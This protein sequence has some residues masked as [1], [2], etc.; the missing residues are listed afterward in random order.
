MRLIAL[1]L[2]S[3]LLAACDTA[4]A[5]TRLEITPFP[6][7]TP[8]SVVLGE[9]LPPASL[10]LN[11]DGLS[12]PSTPAVIS[13]GMTATPD[14]SACPPP[15]ST[16]RLEDTPPD[17]AVVLVEE[18]SRFLNQGGDPRV[19]IDTLQGR[20][21]VIPPDAIARADFDYTGE[22]VAD[23]LLPY[24]ARDGRAGL[25]VMACRISRFEI[26]LEADADGEAP[27]ILAYGDVN[28]DRRND[29]MFAFRDCSQTPLTPEVCP[30]RTRLVTYSPGRARFVDLLPSNVVSVNPPRVI[31]FDTDE[32]SELV[33][34]LESRGSAETGPLR[35]GS[36]IYD[37]NGS[38]YVLSI[39]ELDP[40]AFKIQVLQEGDKTLLRGDLPGALGI[41]QTALSDTNLR[42]WFNDEPDLLQ[43]YTLFRLLQ[44]QIALAD[45]GFIATES[46]INST[47]PD[48]AAAPIYAQMARA[49]L[50]A[51]QTTADIHSA[52]GS[53]ASIIASRPEAVT[54][55]NRYGSRS[56]SYTAPDLCPF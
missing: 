10:L 56:P 6:T 39:V 21:G 24:L 1:L 29:V 8:G 45:P 41:Y 7:T 50:E 33:V 22:G 34:A 35:T 38:E 51:Y 53:V 9:L 25:L 40:P 49:F 46:T 13:A 37:W 3:L 26:L 48:P 4:P 16:V 18:I 30:Y 15:D 19:L 44:T 12:I 32:V 55:L 2:L 20:W 14:F 23:V 27:T 28:R 43:S 5:P 47:Y 36:N 52:C 17:N 11:Q 31:D 42:F 54:Q